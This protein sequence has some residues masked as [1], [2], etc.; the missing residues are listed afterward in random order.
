MKYY[1]ALWVLVGFLPVE[2][3]NAQSQVIWK[4]SQQANWQWQL[5]TPVNLTMDAQIYDIDLFDNDASVVKSLHGKGRKV[6]C[7]LSA[8]TYERWR[9]DAVQFPES[10][11]GQT[12]SG[13]S[14][15]RWLDI[16]RLDVLKPIIDARLDLCK[17]KGFDGVEPDNVDGY[18]NITGFPL[19]AADQIR[20]NTYLADA[21]HARG[22]SVGLKNDLDQVAELQPIFDWALNEQ[23]FQY[24]ECDMLKPF[25][26]AG[27]AV[28]Q[29]EYKLAASRFC[30]AANSMNMNSMVKKMS[31]DATR[32]PCRTVSS[33]PV[34]AG[35]ANAA[36]RGG[37]SVAPGMLVVIS[38]TNLNHITIDGEAVQVTYNTGTEAVVL[39]PYS[40]AGKSKTDVAAES[41]GVKSAPFSVPVTAAAP[42]IFTAQAAGAGQIAMF[43]HDATNN[44]ASQPARAGT[45]VTF[46]A[47]GE[48]RTMP[49]GTDDGVNAAGLSRPELPVAVMIGGYSAEVLYAGAAPGLSHGVMQVS[50]RVPE[51][52]VSANAVPVVLSVGGIASQDQVTMA[53]KGF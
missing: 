38:G 42:A 12:V 19:T 2:A 20:F 1:Y 5:S 18:S 32:T 40:V 8:G 33:D 13:F 39:T 9:P 49:F 36:S 21:A 17:A 34:I 50:V 35:V 24:K 15:E 48:G 46:Y 43:N 28:F 16:R 10:V 30:P 3:D 7:Y 11:K 29:V 52:V 44:S 51:A 45:I 27:K 6:I 4:P 31:L 25:L 47:T 14:N 37:K 53:V 22:L 26:K 23:C 41:N